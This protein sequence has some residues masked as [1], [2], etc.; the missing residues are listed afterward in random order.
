MFLS[1]PPFWIY[2]IYKCIQH[3]KEMQISHGIADEAS[4]VCRLVV[5]LWYYKWN[6]SKCPGHERVKIQTLTDNWAETSKEEWIQITARVYFKMYL[7]LTNLA[8]RQTGSDKINHLTRLSFSF[9]RTFLAVSTDRRRRRA[10][11]RCRSQR[12]IEAS[13]HTAIRMLLSRLKLVCRMADVHLGRVSVE[14]LETREETAFYQSTN[15][16]IKQSIKRSRKLVFVLLLTFC[17]DWD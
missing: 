9:R 4:W 7:F 15:R 2:H 10:T 12:Q 16:S 3:G 6:G 8:G 13:S 5:G 1:S 11:H 14:H 17:F